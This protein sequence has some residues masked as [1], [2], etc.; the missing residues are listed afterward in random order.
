M[1]FNDRGKFFLK[2]MNFERQ[3]FKIFKN[4]IKFYEN[5]ICLSDHIPEQ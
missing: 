1:T 3:W 5:F 2:I 4:K